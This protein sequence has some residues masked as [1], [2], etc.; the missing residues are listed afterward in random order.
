M[1]PMTVMTFNIRYDDP[2]DGRHA[3]PHRRA[4]A[5]A[6]IRAHD[7]DLLGVQEPLPS[8]RHDIEAAMPDRRSFG[9]SQKPEKPGNEE[10]A[11]NLDVPCG[12]VR[13]RRFDILDAGR[14]WLSETPEIAGSTSW[15][16]DWGP[17]SCAWARLRDR[18][19]ERDLVF[20]CTHLDT[21]PGAWLPSARLLHARLDAIASGAALALVGDFNAPAGSDAYRYLGETAGFRDAWIDAGH[22]EH[23][24]ETFHGFA[25]VG[26]PASRPRTSSG[27]L[28]AGGGRI[29]WILL[30][31]PFA[32]T[33]AHIDRR[34]HDGLFP[35]D[36][37][38]VIASIEWRVGLSVRGDSAHSRQS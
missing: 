18:Q 13:T 10:E 6:A 20:A 38:P 19:A 26:S 36:H 30:R 17:R 28:Y 24:A 8:Q 3:W 7:P 14:F 22:G 9:T 33:T 21:N 5:L 34:E 29:D 31:G 15:P 16:N 35:S 23:G 1:W 12:F 32:C 25:P 37:Y 11:D 27:H 4:L 2:S